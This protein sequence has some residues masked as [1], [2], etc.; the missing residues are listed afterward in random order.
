[1]IRFISYIGPKDSKR[2]DL[3]IGNSVLFPKGKIVDVVE[4]GMS[5]RLK[6]DLLNTGLF[7][8]HPSSEPAPLAEGHLCPRCG[9]KAKNKA[10]LSAHRRRCSA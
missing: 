1:M 5:D 4:A 7:K 9:F 3:G 8:L 10:G 6:H 2:I